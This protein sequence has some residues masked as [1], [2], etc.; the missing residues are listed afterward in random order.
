MSDPIKCIIINGDVL[1]AILLVVVLAFGIA[2]G[3]CIE[4]IYIRRKYR[5]I[6]GMLESLRI[7]SIEV[8]D[9]KNKEEE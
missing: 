8:E 3:C 7:R 2:L 1:S 5:P 9:V 6:F 4:Y